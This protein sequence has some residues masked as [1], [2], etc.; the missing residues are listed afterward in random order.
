PHLDEPEKI[1]RLDHLARALGVSKTESRDAEPGLAP[2][3]APAEALAASLSE[4]GL[5]AVHGEELLTAFRRDA[6]Q[7]RYGDWGALMDYCRHS[8]VPCARYLLALHDEEDEGARVAADALATALQVINHIQDCRTDYL[9]LDRVYIPLDWMEAEGTCINDLSRAQATPALRRVL[10][11]MLDG[12]DWLLVMANPLPSRTANL[13]LSLE[14]A[15]TLEIAR[16]LSVQLRREDPLAGRVSLGR[17]AVLAACTRGVFG[18][19]KARF[20]PLAS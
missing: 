18:G 13:R 20:R 16:R 15:V 19:L 10:N 4:T 3:V 8:A 7:N 1:A 9:R 14:A 5:S 12:V 11:R 17:W 2:I 6:A